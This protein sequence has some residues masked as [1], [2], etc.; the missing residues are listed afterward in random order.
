LRQ[1]EQ[2]ANII[3]TMEAAHMMHSSTLVLLLTRES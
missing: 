3:C 2:M 1:A